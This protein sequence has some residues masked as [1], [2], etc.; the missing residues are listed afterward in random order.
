MLSRSPTY[1]KD[2]FRED[3]T[4][5]PRVLRVSIL[6][7]SPGHLHEEL[8]ELKGHDA[9]SP[10]CAPCVSSKGFGGPVEIIISAKY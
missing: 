3:C 1:G 2:S 8:C 4:K 5:Q 10:V 7:G 9:Q 6:F